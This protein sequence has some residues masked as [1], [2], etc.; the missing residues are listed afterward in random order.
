[1]KFCEVLRSSDAVLG[2]IHLVCACTYQGVRNVSFSEKFEYV[3][4][5]WYPSIISYSK[6]QSRGVLSKRCSENMQQIYRR[7]PMPKCDSNKV[8]KQLYWSN[9]L[10]ITLWHE[11]SPVNLLHVFRTPFTKNTSE[12]LL[13][14][15]PTHSQSNNAAVFISHIGVIWKLKVKLDAF[16]SMQRALRYLLQRTN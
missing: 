12:W 16:I 3:L 15:S 1:M 5:E 14:F 6:Q 13:L 9:F 7:T 8:A 4:N 2:I 10:E 11:C